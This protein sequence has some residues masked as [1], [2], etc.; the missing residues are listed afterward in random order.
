MASN[1]QTPLSG[2][3]PDP[4]LEWT[5]RWDAGDEG[6]VVGDL[7][8]GGCGEQQVEVAEVVVQGPHGDPGPLGHLPGRGGGIARP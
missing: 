6:A 8:V 5:V 2:Q 1:R 3:G 4:D 7:P